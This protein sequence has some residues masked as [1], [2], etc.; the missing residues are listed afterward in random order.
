MTDLYLIEPETT[1][2]WSPF[3][4]CRPTSELR[5]GAWLV[6]ERWEAIAEGETR[7]IFGPS[8]LHGFT[9]EG[10]ATVGAATSVDGPALMEFVVVE[11]ENVFP[12]V[13]AGSYDLRALGC[14]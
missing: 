1:T 10:V 13:P 2:A 6:R 8:G 14:F 5:A 3:G 12:M 11:D 7:A 9:E 4:R